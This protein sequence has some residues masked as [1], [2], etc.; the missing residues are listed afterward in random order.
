MQKYNAKPTM[1]DKL[2]KK[3][4]LDPLL[5]MTEDPQF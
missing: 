1:E 4:H 5:G 2:K 3:I